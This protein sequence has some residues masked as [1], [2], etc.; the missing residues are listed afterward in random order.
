MSKSNNAHKKRHFFPAGIFLIFGLTGV[1]LLIVGFILLDSSLKFR[2]IAVEVSGTIS[3]IQTHSRSD[4]DVGH[5]VWVSYEYG[6]QTYEHV[7]LNYY[8]SGMFVGKE[9]SLLVDPAHSTRMTS[10]AGD[11]LGYGV[12]LGM[13]TVF[14][15]VGFIPT[16]CLLTSSA[17]DRKLLRDGRR[18]QAAVEQVDFNPSV[19]YNGRHP[20]VVYCTYWD[21]YRDV[22]YRFKSKNLMRE[23]GYAPGDPI[24]VYVNPCD[25]SKYL[26]DTDA[27][28]DPRVIDYT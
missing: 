22:T 28:T 5:T 10:A 27:P 25:Y 9:I 13:G 23:P 17:R 3:E 21:S 12:F 11:A 7:P 19:T 6:G 4:G 14:S 8:S 16:I 26:V 1:G 20:Y 2:R 15:L 18:L 24:D